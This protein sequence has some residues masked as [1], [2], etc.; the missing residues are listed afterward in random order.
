MLEASSPK[1]LHDWLSSLLSCNFAADD[2]I[3]AC[4]RPALD[5]L[6]YSPNEAIRLA[7]EKLHTFHYSQVPTSWRRLFEEAS[8]QKARL[9]LEHASPDVAR[10]RYSPGR[11]HQFEQKRLEDENPHPQKDWITELVQVLDK[12]AIISGVP[13]RG[14]V[15]HEL[16]LGLEEFLSTTPYNCSDDSELRV[17]RRK[18]DPS[19]SYTKASDP[20]GKELAIRVKHTPSL[21]RPISRQ[22]APS[23]HEFQQH[24]DKPTVTPLV[25]THAL[26]HWPALNDPARQWSNADYLLRKTLGGRRLVPVEFGRSYTDA[27]WSQR[28]VTFAEFLQQCLLRDQS[29][30]DNVSDTDTSIGYLAQHD[31]FSQIP[32]LRADI[33]IPDYCYSTP[34]A[35]DNP[36]DLDEPLVNAWFGPGGTISPLHTDPYHNIFCQVVGYKYLR[37]Y[38]PDQTPKLYPR[39]NDDQGIDMSNTS[40]VDVKQF[41]LQSPSQSQDAFP[42]FR[43]ANYVECVL[44]PGECLYV[45]RGW[46]HYVESLSTSFSVSFWWN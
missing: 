34:P 14:D 30:A 15:I 31:L 8:L 21:Q 4:G 7:H 16:M 9:I 19:T 6:Q 29:A 45:P 18:I 2:P 37:L 22:K 10:Y 41:E 43:E 26:D 20:S 44:G 36:P 33:S 5:V 23:L 32:P 40:Q 27:G 28:I 25:I 1:S 39:G 35:P 11:P 17:K 38:A 42:L 3:T 24:L 12:A 13:K 46:W